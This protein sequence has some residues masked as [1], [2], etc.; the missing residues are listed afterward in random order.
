MNEG[1]P[2]T[3][4]VC[5][6]LFKSFHEQG[7][8]YCHWKSNEHLAE[9]LAGAT[10]LDIIVERRQ[11]VE[12]ILSEQGFKQFE[13]AWFA[14]H[15]GLA[16]YL[17]Y[18][19]ATGKLVHLHL[20]YQLAIGN[21]RLKD[22]NLPWA[23]TLLDRRVF[24]ETYNV[25]RADPAM[26][27]CLLLVRYALK[28]QS[29]DYV[30]S[31][32][33][34]Y[35]DTDVVK[36]YDWLRER[37][38]RNEVLQLTENLLNNKAANII[39][40]M[41]VNTPRLWQFRALR[42]QCVKEL[43]AVRTYGYTEAKARG[44]LREVFLGFRSI[45]ERFIGQP[46]FYRRTV[47][48]GGVMVVLLGVDGAGKSTIIEELEEWLSW[49]LDVQRIYF[50]SGDGPATLLRYPLIFA[51][52]RINNTKKGSKVEQSTGKNSLSDESKRPL[53]LRIGRVI[54]GLVLARE[55][56]KKLQKG[57]RAKN[58]GLVVLGDRYP[59]NQIMGFNDGPLL[60]HL[61]DSSSGL[62]RSLARHERDIY[63]SAEEHPPDLVIVLD[64]QP[65]TAMERK[66]EMPLERFERR[67]EAIDDL[68][69]DTDCR[70]VDAEQPLEDV[71]RDIKK[72]VWE[73]L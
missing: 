15:H 9:G 38:N 24:D 72:L 71:I 56:Q 37:A 25:Y 26:E 60:D 58:R 55:R 22:Y 59:Q 69:F 32:F 27:L 1:N 14:D 16:D 64:V 49:K 34:E 63:R 4:D 21:K 18:D 29:R 39:N 48:S 7:V 44:F 42:K 5:T 65:E 73:I 57:Q 62:L 43:S 2:V 30:K 40:R 36:E 28:I 51:R 66:P 52:K 53:L 12:R 35:L 50:G 45:N 3:L 19:P 67:K 13:T 11:E 20:H 8:K 33:E 31:V 41:L 61:T 6:K 10:D 46:R 70:V 54:R 47:P 68:K 23:E 17:G